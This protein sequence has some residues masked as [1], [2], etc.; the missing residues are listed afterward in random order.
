MKSRLMGAIRCD[1]RTIVS[2]RRHKGRSAGSC[3]CTA[4]A[5]G[6]AGR[7]VLAR[8]DDTRRTLAP[9]PIDALTR[10]PSVPRAILARCIGR[11]YGRRC[12]SAGIPTVTRRATPRLQACLKRRRVSRLDREVQRPSDGCL[13]RRSKTPCSL[14]AF[15]APGDRTVWVRPRDHRHFERRL[16]NPRGARRDTCSGFRLVLLHSAHRFAPG[17]S[18]NAHQPSGT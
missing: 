15:S 5:V 11:R 3:W 7:R 2:T 14:E 13:A 12:V 4:N 17:V 16:L 10:R 1:R 9:S 8:V 6:G 18:L